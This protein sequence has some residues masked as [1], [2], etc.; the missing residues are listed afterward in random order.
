MA[1]IKKHYP[2]FLVLVLVLSLAAA[3]VAVAQDDSSSQPWSSLKQLYLEKLAANLGIDVDRLQ[4]AMQNAGQQTVEAAQTSGLI[5]SDKAERL[6]KALEDGQWPGFAG[7]KGGPRDR[8]FGGF[9]CAD[10]I[11][12]VLG[13]TPQ[14]L[15]QELQDGKTLEQIAAEKGLTLD[16]LKEKLINE[17]KTKLDEAVASGKLTR[18]KADK[19]LS[20]LEQLDL[21]KLLQP[22]HPR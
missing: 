18:D 17:A 15:R 20:G 3:G 12:N 13:I 2:L 6:Q 11:A 14:E 19:I 8:G 7:F 10:D 21:S 16:Q 22:R 9:K 5:D 4:E 1:K